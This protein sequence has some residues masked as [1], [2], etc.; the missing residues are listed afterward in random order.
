MP[1]TLEEKKKRLINRLQKFFLRESRI[2]VKDGY[3]CKRREP[4]Y[5]SYKPM[6]KEIKLVGTEVI[7]F[8]I[9]FAKMKDIVKAFLPEDLKTIDMS[10]IKLIFLNFDDAMEALRR[11][12]R[13]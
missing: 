8:G 4:A 5:K 13:E 12:M 3:F 6:G 10:H 1:G 7:L 2:N 9:D 11:N